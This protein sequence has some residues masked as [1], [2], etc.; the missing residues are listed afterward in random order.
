MSCFLLGCRAELRR[1]TE[2]V[3]F[4]HDGVSASGCWDMAGNVGEW[5]LDN[6]APDYSWDET[7]VDPVYVSHETHQHVVRGGSGLHDE[8]CLRCSSRDYYPPELRDNIVGMR[9]VRKI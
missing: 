9:C 7:G 6:Y 4:H 2:R 3:D 8:D 5:C 1:R